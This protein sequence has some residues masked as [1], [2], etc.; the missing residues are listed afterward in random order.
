MPEQDHARVQAAC[1]AGYDPIAC[2][3]VK[4]R[5]HLPGYRGEE[6]G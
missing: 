6:D 5:F 1:K 2:D 3:M 4:E